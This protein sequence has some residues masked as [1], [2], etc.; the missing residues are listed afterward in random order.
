MVDEPAATA[1]AFEY[2]NDDMTASF[3]LRPRPDFRGPVPEDQRKISQ[4]VY[5][6][7]NVLQLLK[8]DKAIGDAVFTE[9]IRR[10]TQAGRAGCVADNVDTKLAAE[11]LD[12][13]RAD[14]VRRAATPLVYRY[15]RA[16]AIW[17]AIGGVLGLGFAIVGAYHWPIV[18][19][20]SCVLIGATAGAWFSAAAA[21]WKISFGTIP[22]YPDIQLEPVI[23]MLFVALVAVVFALFLHL[24]LITIKV[25]N[26]NFA[27]F[28]ESISV[29]LLVGF[30]AGIGQRVLSVQLTERAEKFLPET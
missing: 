16:L 4:D 3:N 27:D 1:P 30:V 19:G 22:D 14:I 8:D 28:T 5:E 23:R 29:A 10:V 7:R 25:G 20:Y 26:T 15:L 21:R 13:I 17:A 2:E 18:K 6:A 24:G 12:Q 11:A 9:F